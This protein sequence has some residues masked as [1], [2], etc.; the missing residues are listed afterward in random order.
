MTDEK[1]PPN[2]AGFELSARAWSALTQVR[3]AAPSGVWMSV[4]C[5][6]QT[7]WVTFAAHGA[8]VA[9]GTAVDALLW[10]Q[11]FREWIDELVRTAWSVLSEA[12]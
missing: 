9:K 6:G 3:N 8:R 7:V 1:A 12:Q 2:P 10:M 5:D 11:D 4:H